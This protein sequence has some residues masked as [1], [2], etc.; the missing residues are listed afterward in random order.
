[1][2]SAGTFFIR[3]SYDRTMMLDMIPHTVFDAGDEGCGNLVMLVMKAMQPLAAG[4][5]LAVH[6]TDPAAVVDI[7]AWC[8]LT[9]H[10]LLSDPRNI[11]YHTYYIRKKDD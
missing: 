8:A 4:Q 5:V 3:E 6:A 2:R 10:E 7:P 1:M 9:G 11:Q